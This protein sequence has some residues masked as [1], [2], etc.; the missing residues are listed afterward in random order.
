[1]AFFILVLTT[2]ILEYT[3]SEIPCPLCLLQRLGLLAISAG[4]LCNLRFGCKPSHYAL[5]LFAALFSATVAIRQILLHIVPGT[6]SYGS[7]IF[8]LHLYTWVLIAAT[9]TIL[10]CA[11]MLLHTKSFQMDHSKIVIKKSKIFNSLLAAIVLLTLFNAF[12]SL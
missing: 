11:C 12:N 1:M 4:F 10:F 9:L 3:L 7:P 5:S 6:G 2:A 8:D